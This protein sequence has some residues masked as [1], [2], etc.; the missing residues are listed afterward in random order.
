MSAVTINSYADVQTALS[1]LLSANS[2]SASNAPHQVFWQTLSYSDFVN[3]NVPNLGIPILV[4]GDSANSNIIQVLT[5][6]AANKTGFPDMPYP[7]PPYDSNTPTQADVLSALAGWIDAKCPEFASDDLTKVEG[8]GPKTQEALNKHGITTFEQLSGT[9]VDKLR[10]ILDGAGLGSFDPGSWPA[11]ANLAHNSE[12][13]L[14]ESVQ[15]HLKGGR[16][17]KAETSSESTFN[18][19]I[20]PAI[21]IARVGNSS[22][23]YLGPETGAG[24]TTTNPDGPSGGLPIKP[25]TEST[26][27][28]SSDI[29][30][31]NVPDPNSG[32][33]NFASRDYKG[34]LKRQGARFKIYQYADQGDDEK[35]PLGPDATMGE[36][37]IGSTVGGKTVMDIIWTVHLANKKS[38]FYMADP[39]YKEGSKTEL[40]GGKISFEGTLPPLRNP[41]Y[42]TKG[43]ASNDPLRLKNLFIDPG[44]RTVSGKNTPAVNFD[45]DTTASYY[46][47][48]TKSVATIGNYPK[49]F[50][51]RTNFPDLTEPQGPIDTLGELQTDGSGRLIVTGGYGRSANWGNTALT[52]PV[53][54]DGWF[55]DAGDGPVS[56][57]LVMDDGTKMSVHGSAW[58]AVTDPSFAPQIKNVVS[59]WEDIYNSWVRDLKLVPDLYDPVKYK[60]SSIPGYNDDYKPGFY[61]QLS[62]VFEGAELQQW[63]ANLNSQGTSGHDGA[64]SITPDSTPSSYYFNVLRNPNTDPQN[65]A[66]APSGSMTP[67]MPLALGDNGQAFLSVTKTQYFF[68]SQW[69]A[70]KFNP[71]IAPLGPGELLDQNVLLNC[72]GGR[73]SPGIDLT[74]TVRQSDLYIDDWASSGKGPFRIDEQRLHY[75][76]ITPGEAFL[77]EGYVPLHSTTGIQPGDLTKL[78]ALPWHTDY[79]SCANH[80]PQVTPTYPNSAYDDYSYWSWPAQR[81]V[82]AFTSRKKLKEKEQWFTLRG[83]GTAP[84]DPSAPPAQGTPA[85]NVCRYQTIVDIMTN[86]QNVGV[87][88]QSSVVD[89]V[90]PAYEDKYYLESESNFP[91]GVEVP[92]W[93]E[94]LPTDDS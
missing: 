25:G 36:I 74:W 66:Y 56:A 85:Q 48:Q 18:F 82:V 77:T 24:D 7:S 46:N 29:R 9:N 12:T 15:D 71:D 42:P 5:G 67:Y 69:V 53:D 83:Y 62:G 64:G 93:P 3:G 28:T 55:D 37:K 57:V 68:L 60:D 4:S 45:K 30:D 1:A 49:S 92:A 88:L 10:G 22:E 89:G 35:Y 47:K 34:A 75:D 32:D 23:Y 90:D 2:L 44:P 79:N 59:I 72:L 13:D 43:A 17:P 58:V 39:P 8:I 78:M 54:N 80:P 65:K 86:W 63:I 20:H 19:R 38:Q 40:G 26:T 33:P 73:F 87:I 27:I 70:N 94:Y 52:G 61:N 31:P 81:P 50:P 21:G 6:G 84:G 16:V 11:Q 14:L 76:Q 41:D 91:D 51:D